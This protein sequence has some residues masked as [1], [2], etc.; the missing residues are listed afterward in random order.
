MTE[1]KRVR[2]LSLGVIKVACDVDIS[3]QRPIYTLLV[4]NGAG[5]GLVARGPFDSYRC[6]IAAC[7]RAKVPVPQ[8]AES[9]FGFSFHQTNKHRAGSGFNTIQLEKR[10]AGI[11]K[12]FDAIYSRFCDLSTQ[13]QALIADILPCTL[14]RERDAADL[15]DLVTSRTQQ[16]ENIA[17]EKNLD[18]VE[19]SK[20]ISNTTT[21]NKE[22]KEN[23]AS[24]PRA[25]LLNDDVRVHMTLDLNTSNMSLRI[26]VPIARASLVTSNRTFEHFQNLADTVSSLPTVTKTIYLPSFPERLVASQR[27][28]FKLT[29]SQLESRR[30]KLQNYISTLISAFPMLAIDDQEAIL[31]AL[32]LEFEAWMSRDKPRIGAIQRDL[33]EARDLDVHLAAKLRYAA[34][35]ED[36]DHFF[37]SSSSSSSTTS[38]VSSP[39]TKN[40]TEKEQEQTSQ[41]ESVPAPWDEAPG[42][43]ESASL[44]A[45]LPAAISLHKR[46]RS[47]ELCL[48]IQIEGIAKLAETEFRNYASARPKWYIKAALIDEFCQAEEEI[49]FDRTPAVSADDDPSWSPF[50][51]L[52][53]ILPETRS[54]KIWDHRKLVFRLYDANCGKLPP[55]LGSKAPKYSSTCSS[56]QKNSTKNNNDPDEAIVAY[57]SLGGLQE[58]EFGGPGCDEDPTL[59]Q[60]ELDLLD[61]DN[62]F[63]G[64]QLRMHICLTSTEVALDF[65]AVNVVAAIKYDKYV[66][67]K[68]STGYG[69]LCHMCLPSFLLAEPA[70]NSS[71]EPSNNKSNTSTSIIDKDESNWET[72]AYFKVS[73]FT[74]PLVE[75][76][77]KFDLVRDPDIMN[78]A[79]LPDDGSEA[80]LLDWHTRNDLLHTGGYQF[81]PTISAKNW[82]PLHTVTTPIRRSVY[83]RISKKRP[84]EAV[85]QTP[86]PLNGNDQ[87]S[88]PILGRFQAFNLGA[89]K[90]IK[91]ITPAA[92]IPNNTTSSS[93][94]KSSPSSTSRVSFLEV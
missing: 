33:S 77:T 13:H 10:R 52:V 49:R 70:N 71:V 1:S 43:I 12:L 17:E 30:H 7:R 29:H 60:V 62:R 27:L 61:R 15:Y 68:F 5:E 42:S 32:E 35:A 41:Q 74:Q 36:D 85:H 20:I 82:T 28:G 25:L 92:A 4:V 3:E 21:S 93:P 86:H 73:D 59:T 75:I 37:T 94:A 66:G 90:K 51:P 67:R 72:V 2:A 58:F 14:L 65:T 40:N 26:S 80:L 50:Y 78:L 47:G 88:N 9:L 34:K 87:T 23:A 64:A 91:S 79:P 22:I 24:H 84:D 8:S 54:D 83:F 31:D 46:L 56:L 53:L 63:S 69:S 44:Q 55:G 81:A 57:A 11:E 18:G 19:E 6:A 76:P 16:Q 39:P 48:L 89:G 38:K 45:V